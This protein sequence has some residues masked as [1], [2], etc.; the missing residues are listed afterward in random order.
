MEQLVRQKIIFNITWI[1]NHGQI[2]KKKKKK[3][4]GFDNVQLQAFG[5]TIITHYA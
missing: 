3:N 4:G 1:K 5:N 2:K